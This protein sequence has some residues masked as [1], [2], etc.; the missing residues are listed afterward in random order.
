ME[1]NFSEFETNLIE[2]KLQTEEEVENYIS[3]LKND[4]VYLNKIN[5]IG[6]TDI[7]PKYIAE[8][9]IKGRESEYI[10]ALAKYFK[11]DVAAWVH[12]WRGKNGLR[13]ADIYADRLDVQIEKEIK[14]YVDV[15]GVPKLYKII[16]ENTDDKSEF[17]CIL[18]D[19]LMEKFGGTDFCKIRYE[20]SRI[21]N[22]F[23]GEFEYSYEERLH[24]RRFYKECK[25]YVD[26]ELIIFINY[27][28]KRGLSIK[29]A[30]IF[31][32]HT[33]ESAFDKKLEDIKQEEYDIELM[34]LEQKLS[35]LDNS[36]NISIES[37]DYMSGIEFENFVYK[38][39]IKMGYYAEKTPITG[40]QGVDLILYNDKGAKIA[41]QCKRNQNSIGNTAIQ[42]VVAGAVFYNANSTMVVTNNYFTKSAID[43]ANSCN[44]TLCDRDMLSTLISE[45]YI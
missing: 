41:V 14:N 22:F 21:K 42:E 34:K 18:S 12:I 31:F 15:I 13:L 5:R 36:N 16:K 7:F 3:S 26:K 17:F 9:T 6:T 43:L 32:V 20:E 10:T 24:K 37:T 8:G 23:S 29:Y 35:N 33:L 30:E 4:P 11:S 44:T 25:N 28:E 40:D 1:Y 19:V 45:H 2:S 38:L 39:F 27:L